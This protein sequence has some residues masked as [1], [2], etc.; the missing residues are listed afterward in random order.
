MANWHTT[1]AGSYLRHP[2][3]FFYTVSMNQHDAPAFTR[4]INL[5]AAQLVR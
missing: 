4:L 5:A 1:V 3:K 2:E